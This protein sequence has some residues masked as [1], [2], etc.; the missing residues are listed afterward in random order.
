MQQE[1]LCCA[2][3]TKMVTVHYFGDSDWGSR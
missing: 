3:D 2:G 1:V